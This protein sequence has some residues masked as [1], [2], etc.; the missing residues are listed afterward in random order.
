M[1]S[2]MAAEQPSQGDKPLDQPRGNAPTERERTP[3]APP[4]EQGGEKDGQKPGDEQQKA[5]EEPK[6]NQDN[7]PGGENRPG[8]E[9]KDESGQ[10]VAHG[11]DTD[12]WGF[13]PARVQETF[14]NQGGDDMPVRYREWID[15]YYRRLNKNR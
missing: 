1:Q 5:G 6:G 8:T 12:S 10:P 11:D 4:E 7:P 3:E 9:R 14:R 15:S 13:L 2:G